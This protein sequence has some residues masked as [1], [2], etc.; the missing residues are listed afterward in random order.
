[1]V[2]LIAVAAIVYRRRR[3]QIKRIPTGLEVSQKDAGAAV[4]AFGQ[5]NA[6]G[7]ARGQYA[8]LG[9]QDGPRRELPPRVHE[10]GTREEAR[11]VEL[12]AG[13]RS[14]Y[15]RGSGSI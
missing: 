12:P 6:Y 14:S 2:L 5:G 1:L 9:G 3:S 10:M 7:P 13:G 4:W 11:R 15:W 8:E